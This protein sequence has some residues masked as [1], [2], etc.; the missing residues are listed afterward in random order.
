MI[1]KA[2]MSR[3]GEAPIFARLTISGQRAEFNINW[4]IQSGLT[5]TVKVYFKSG[6]KVMLYQS[7]GT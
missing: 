6:Y 5:H 3:S 2:R 7:D 1:R 4:K